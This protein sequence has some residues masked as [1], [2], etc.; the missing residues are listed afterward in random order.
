M[1]GLNSLIN[2]EWFLPGSSLKLPGRLLFKEKS[3]KIILQIFGDKYIEGEPVISPEPKD[4]RYHS[5][6]YNDK[7]ANA[8]LLIN[9]IGRETV[10]LY[11]ARWAGTKDI[12]KDIYLIKYDIQFVFFGS[13][14]TSI[15]TFLLTSAT[16]IFPYLSTWFDGWESLDKMRIFEDKEFSLS[17]FIHNKKAVPP[18][19]VRDGLQFIIYDEYRKSMKE[20][21]VHHSVRFQKKIDFQYDNPVSFEGLLDDI[22]IFGKL[23][24]FCFGKQI[25]EK[26]LSVTF[27]GDNKR[28]L[29]GNYSL[30][31]GE[32]INQHSQHQNYILLSR[33]IMESQ[34]LI[35][36][37][38]KWYSNKSF[39]SIY[40][41]YNDSNY[42]FQHEQAILSNVMFNNRFLN[43]VQGLESFYHKTNPGKN[44]IKNEIAKNE[45]EKNKKLIL[46]SIKDK[47]LKE[48]TNSNLNFKEKIKKPPNLEKILTLVIQSNNEIL[49]PIFGK[50]EIVDFFPRFASKIRNNLS[51]GL[52]EKTYQGEVLHVMFHFGQIL[53][54]IC[55]LKSLEVADI[56]KKIQHYD[57]FKRS[58]YEIQ[59]S[60][61]KF[62]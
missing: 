1:S 19:H 51:H 38:Q 9:G 49:I 32:S 48:W 35:S 41:I 40:D 60:K 44:K 20:I 17:D 33:W 6:N 25:N 30:H 62:V 21:G 47:Q 27:H 45:F 22:S 37:I 54:A 13:H 55:I 4:K 16:L 34:D 36:V 26:L 5:K 52:H 7:Y 8:H 39:F 61:L 23:L 3:K 43:I 29:V 14:I 42:W 59:I 2:G 10:T 53:L 12:G 15:D 50:S 31:H 18:V 58:I 46:A 24:E 57:N 11:N 28:L 56:K